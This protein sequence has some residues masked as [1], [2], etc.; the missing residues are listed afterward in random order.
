[1]N[2]I[3]VPEYVTDPK[4]KAEMLMNLRYCQNYLTVDIRD[5]IAIPPY[6]NRG[7]N[8]DE[9]LH[10]ATDGKIDDYLEENRWELK[11]IAN[12]GKPLPDKDR[13]QKDL[14]LISKVNLIA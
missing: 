1:M 4:I 6:P 5:T 13:D 12:S 14:D 2:E 11:E 7:P 8:F 9:R 3:R 10:L